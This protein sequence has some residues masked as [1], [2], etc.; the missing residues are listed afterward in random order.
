MVEARGLACAVQSTSR[1][2]YPPP[3]VYNSAGLSAVYSSRRYCVEDEDP[4]GSIVKDGLDLTN[5][6]DYTCS[7]SSLSAIW[8]PRRRNRRYWISIGT[9]PS[10]RD[11]VRCKRVGRNL[12]ATVNGLQL[13]NGQRYYFSVWHKRG[14]RCRRSRC[15]RGRRRFLGVSDGVIVDTTPPVLG[16][17]T[18]KRR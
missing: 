18:V 9:Y 12:Q 15:C 3:Q 7:T 1:K 10:G 6:V 4:G 14:R 13:Q 2:F 8:T 5:D 11:V 17:V 16:I